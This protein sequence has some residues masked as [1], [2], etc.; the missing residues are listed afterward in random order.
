MPLA[1]LTKRDIKAEIF[2]PARLEAYETVIFS[3]CYS[4]E[5]QEEARHLRA[6]GARVILDLCDNHFYNP[7]ELP[8]YQ[9]VRADL[10]A[11]I[12]LAD[13]IVC[14][15]KALAE[16]VAQEAGLDR[17]PHIIDDPVEPAPRRGLPRVMAGL[18][19]R[20]NRNRHLELLWFG[21]HGSPNA[22]GGMRDIENLE[23]QISALS[24]RLP[25]TVTVCSN[26]RPKY[27]K[28]IA[29]LSFASNYEEW[30]PGAQ[31][32]LLR[33]ASA[34]IIPISQ[35]PFTRCKTH[36]R[37]TLALLYGVPV[38]A[39]SIPSYSPLGDY[40]VLDDWARG[41][42]ELENDPGNAKRRAIA[43][44]CYV[45][46]RYSVGNIADEWQKLLLPSRD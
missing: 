28:H 14:S 30:N 21:S 46:D 44:Q 35:N 3:K 1:A 32:R 2:D 43:G 9:R 4:Q 17:L 7:L 39:D 29:P 45:R 40:C 12:A 42:E 31:R 33:R 25:V 19:R 22:E 34:V 16:V 26:N 11:M 27:D 8:A 41:L 20:A 5:S 23:K 37:L 6:K 15:T 10:L 13:D 18:R 36:N 38:I 24:E